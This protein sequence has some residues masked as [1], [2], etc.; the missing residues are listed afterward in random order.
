[1]S[2]SFSWRLLDSISLHSARANVPGPAGCDA[3]KSVRYDCRRAL[4]TLSIDVAA[5]GGLD[6]CCHC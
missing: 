1:M 2:A 3:A 6:T 5:Y 4:M